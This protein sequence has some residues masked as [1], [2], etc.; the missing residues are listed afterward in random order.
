MSVLFF[1]GVPDT[2]AVWQPLLGA[3]AQNRIEAKTPK[4]PGFGTNYP[5][6]FQ[7]TKEGYLDWMFMQ[8]ERE[9]DRTSAPVDIVAHD[10]GALLAQRAIVRRPDLIRSWAISGA[11]LDP[12]YE[13]HETAQK[14]QT[15]L[16]GELLMAITP[17]FA[18]KRALVDGGLPESIAA[19]EVRAWSRPMKQSILSLYRSAKTVA[20][21]WTDD[22]DGLPDRGLIIW[23]EKDPY[24]GLSSARRFAERWSVPIHIEKDAGHWAIASRATSIADVL[25]QHWAAGN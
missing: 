16:L 11:V 15:P 24:V 10:W 9:A 7:P 4:M 23:G 12:D 1:H 3:L 6:H 17:K 18:L 2:S 20:Q 5:E 22:L 25:S 13:W 8:I 14:W 19:K 21:D